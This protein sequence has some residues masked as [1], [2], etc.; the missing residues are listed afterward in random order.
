MTMYENDT[1]YDVMLKIQSD[2][3]RYSRGIPTDC[4]TLFKD[5]EVM[6]LFQPLWYFD[7]H[8]ENTSIASPAKL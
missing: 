2:T 4:Q 3:G 8:P 5:G 1:V 7:I 6:D